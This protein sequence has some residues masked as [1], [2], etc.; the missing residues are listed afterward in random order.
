MTLLY[1]LGGLF[2]IWW[3]I[4]AWRVPKLYLVMA[5]CNWWPKAVIAR[6]HFALMGMLSDICF[7]ALLEPLSW[8]EKSLYPERY[9]PRTRPPPTP[10]ADPPGGFAL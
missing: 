5:F 10:P 6:M 3:F 4:R 8:L 9:T 7:S 1:I 2:A